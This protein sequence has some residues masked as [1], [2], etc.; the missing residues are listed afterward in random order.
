M[1]GMPRREGLP[2]HG[3]GILCEA[4]RF[5][6]VTRLYKQ[7]CK[8]WLRDARRVVRAA[9][10]YPSKAVDV[11]RALSFVGVRS[12]DD[13]LPAPVAVQ[14]ADDQVQAEGRLGPG[15]VG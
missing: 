5:G 15:G 14:V 11:D 4:Q 12:P 7:S 10:S 13:Q 8:A 1:E 3:A 2:E 6:L 9:A